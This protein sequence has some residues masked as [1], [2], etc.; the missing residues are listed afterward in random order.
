MTTAAIMQPTYLPWTGYFGM[1]D[2]VDIFV[3]Y[4]DV[5]FVLTIVAEKE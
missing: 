3:L 1:I 2:T 5:Q 4:D